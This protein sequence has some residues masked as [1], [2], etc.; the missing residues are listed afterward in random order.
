VNASA[1]LRISRWCIA[2]LAALLIAGWCSPSV[3]AADPTFVGV[4]AL[5]TDDDVAKELNLSDEVRERLLELIDQRE[6]AALTL[7]QRIRDHSPEEKEAAL[8]PFVAESERLGLALLMPDQIKRLRELQL[9]RRGLSALAEPQFASRLQLSE[10]QQAEVDRLLA[11]RDEK[12]IA[13]DEDRRGAIRADYE[14]QLR[15]LLQ[16]SQAIA[17][18]MLTGL[19]NGDDQGD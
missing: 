15:G 8:A 1:A 18:D 19:G 5:A 10:A 16:R 17:W 9:L 6:L 7:V 14:R 2:C 11:E 13:A 3:Q 12:I 4:L